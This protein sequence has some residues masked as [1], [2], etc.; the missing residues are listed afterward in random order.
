MANVTCKA[1]D[2]GH[3]IN[4]K[5]CIGTALIVFVP[6]PP[7]RAP[8]GLLVVADLVAAGPVRVPRRDLVLVLDHEGDGVVAVLDGEFAVSGSTIVLVLQHLIPRV[9]GAK[10]NHPGE[11]EDPEKPSEGPYF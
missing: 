3:S 4:S 8:P 11:V 10:E 6:G 2:S 9:T 7:A 1:S 5:I